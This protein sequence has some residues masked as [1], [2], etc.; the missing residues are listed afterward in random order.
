[1]LK[2]KVRSISITTL[3]A[4]PSRGIGW[5]Y[6]TVQFVDE[7]GQRVCRDVEVS[8]ADLPR[9]LLAQMALRR[10]EEG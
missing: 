2:T 7:H 9:V 1:M 10:L 5:T 3:P 6:V 8:N 4:W